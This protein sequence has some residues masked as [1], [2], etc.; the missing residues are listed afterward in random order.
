MCCRQG[1]EFSLTLELPNDGI[2]LMMARRQCG[3]EAEEFASDEMSDEDDDDSD[4]DD[5]DSDEDDE[6]D[7]SDEDDGDD[8]EDE[9]A[10]MFTRCCSK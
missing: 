5:G 9:C 6:S 1:K 10:R 4:E 2:A 3:E 8:A 7:E